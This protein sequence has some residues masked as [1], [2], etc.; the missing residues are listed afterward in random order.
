MP[1]AS[2]PQLRRLAKKGLAWKQI[3][4]RL[5]ISTLLRRMRLECS[6]SM[7]HFAP[8]IYRVTV[9][10]GF[11]EIP[12]ILILLQQCQEQSV[13]VNLQDTTYSQS[14]YLARH[15]E[16]WNGAVAR[17]PVCLFV[18]KR[19]PTRLLL[20]NSLGA[21]CGDCCRR[22]YLEISHQS[23]DPVRTASNRFSWRR[24]E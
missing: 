1:P 7:G 6:N 3:R 15:V 22:G 12:V 10:H 4:I 23:Y 2:K 13:P 16:A 14:N 17:A 21:S 9:R 19:T 20:R 5:R 11:M 8:D 24:S 18:E